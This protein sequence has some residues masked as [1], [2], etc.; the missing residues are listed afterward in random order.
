M[1]QVPGPTPY[2]KRNVSDTV[3]S[4]WRLFIDDVMMKHIIK[5]TEEEAVRQ[6]ADGFS[7]TLEELD[8]FIAVLYARGVTG[9]TK[10]SINDLWSNTWGNLFCKRIMG[11]DRFK[12]IMRYLRFDTKSDRSTRLKTDK[13]ALYSAVWNRFV[14]NC[15][16]C[17]TAGANVT[18]DEQLFP[19]KARCPFT[20]YIPSKPDKFGQKFFLSVDLDSKYV[21]NAIPY[22]GSDDSRPTN[23]RLADHLVLELMKPCLGCGRN[24]T[25]DNFFTSMVLAVELKKKKTSI[26]GTINSK[27]R[28][29][30]E[31]L[32]HNNNPLYST[33]VYKHGDA[34]LTS[35]QGKVNKNILVLST[36]HP[37]VRISDGEKKKPDTVCDYNTTKCGVD[38]VDQMARTC[39]TRAGTRRWPV[40]AFHN[41]LDLAGINAY[42]V[43]T[44]VTG[45]KL[46][47]RAFLQKLVEELS[48]PYISQRSRNQKHQE[49]EDDYGEA[50][51][52]VCKVK[53]NCKR[54]RK[55]GT[56]T[57]CH[58]PVCGKCT[59]KIKYLCVRCEN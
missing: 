31:E 46:S 55:V 43:Y 32:K 59:G 23:R 15:Q 14:N 19:S 22:L 17:Y 33:Q 44:E 53:Q 47:R 34:T 45:T 58:K 11:R 27:R 40:H 21:L 38:I 12:E 3:T 26:L 29:I 16:S 39:T 36:M 9:S 41:T 18:I 2:A 57:S 56:C 50:Q 49:S 13:Y 35:Y 8:A 54:N 42:V 25:T 1:R 30:P 24:V 52:W 4:A 48:A 6:R 37:S 10:I 51:S 28:E 7:L 5:C 20:Q